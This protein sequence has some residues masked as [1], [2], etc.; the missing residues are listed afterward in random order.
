MREGG[1]FKKPEMTKPPE[2][3]TRDG[4]GVGDGWLE[5]KLLGQKLVSRMRGALTYFNSKKRSMKDRERLGHPEI[6]RCADRRCS[7]LARA[8]SVVG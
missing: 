1:Y 2:S 8:G 6:A 3:M 4:P 7:G 5:F